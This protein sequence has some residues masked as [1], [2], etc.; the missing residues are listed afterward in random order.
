MDFVDVNESNA[1]WVQDFRLKA[2]ASPAKL[3]SIDGEGPRPWRAGVFGDPGGLWLDSAIT[4]LPSA[5]TVQGTLLSHILGP[6]FLSSV[7]E[8]RW[9]AR[10]DTV[11]SGAGPPG[12][13][14]I[15]GKGTGWLLAGRS[16]G[17]PGWTSWR[18]G[19]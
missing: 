6:E 18:A 7:W 1:R 15:I 11:R 12:A 16:R 8:E 17:E 10:G 3:E 4:P 9:W 19:S 13:L 5:V 2:Y 14:A